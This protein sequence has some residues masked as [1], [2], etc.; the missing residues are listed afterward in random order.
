MKYKDTISAGGLLPRLLRALGKLD[1]DE[2]AMI[3]AAALHDTRN[4]QLQTIIDSPRPRTLA[5]LDMDLPPEEVRA[6]I[7]YCEER[8]M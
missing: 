1:T 6:V 5:E 2:G 3:L 8:K 4:T 7:R